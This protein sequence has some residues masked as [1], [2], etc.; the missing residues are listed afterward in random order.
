MNTY[1]VTTA[2]R[3][4]HHAL[5]QGPMTQHNHTSLHN[6]TH[7]P[8]ITITSWIGRQRR[9]PRTEPVDHGAE[10]NDLCARAS[11]S[12][13][14]QRGGEGGGELPTCFR[15]VIMLRVCFFLV[16]CLCLFTLHFGNLPT[17]PSRGPLLEWGGLRSSP[18]SHTST[19]DHLT[20]PPG[21]RDLQLCIYF[22]L[23]IYL[24]IYPFPWPGLPR[25]PAPSRH[26]RPH[27]ADLPLPSRPPRVVT[28]A[29]VPIEGRRTGREEPKVEMRA[30]EKL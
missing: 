23:S 10:R 28:A 2:R 13:G 14:D 3:Q 17:L 18:A 1:R 29:D 9:C 6:Q 4:T 16:I 30:G 22:Y 20:N 15:F 21:R 5:N 24:S 19:V 25:P 7:K 11:R 27:L 12:L 26:A 8:R